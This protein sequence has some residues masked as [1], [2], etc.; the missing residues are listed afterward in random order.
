MLLVLALL[1]SAAAH[2]FG[3]TLPGHELRLTV[4]ADRVEL[5]YAA[6]VPTHDVLSELE[7]LGQA[8]AA[9]F[10]DRKLD[11]LADNLRIEADGMRLSWTRA[12]TDAETGLGNSRAI[13]YEQTLSVALPPNTRSLHISNGNYPDQPSYFF[14]SVAL[15]PP[16][17]LSDC[18]LVDIEGARVLRTR[19][20]QWRMDEEQRELRLTFAESTGVL[21]ALGQLAGV[22]GEGPVSLDAAL[23]LGVAHDLRSGRMPPE[24]VALALFGAALGAMDLRRS[25]RLSLPWLALALGGAFAVAPAF[26]GALAAAAAVGAALGAP[27]PA[28]LTRIPGWMGRASLAVFGAAAGMVLLE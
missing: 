13:S 25:W 19:D 7:A 22:P 20:G 1:G 3:G 8:D 6:R 17:R 4:A 18:S 27:A 16:L 14:W 21:A 23:A 15:M 26:G 12:P 28:R 5:R 2:P 24:G 9:A 11:E 10:T